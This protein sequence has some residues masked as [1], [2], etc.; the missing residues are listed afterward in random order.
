[1]IKLSYTSET[2]IAIS[3]L[4]INLSTYISRLMRDFCVY[5]FKNMPFLQYVISRTYSLL[6]SRQQKLILLFSWSNL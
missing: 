5:I 1:M 2:A 6:T 4:V 3:F